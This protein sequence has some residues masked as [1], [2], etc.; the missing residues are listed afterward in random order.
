MAL[1][2]IGF[3]RKEIRESGTDGYPYSLSCGPGASEDSQE[4]K[5][6]DA[7]MIYPCIRDIEG[8]QL[9]DMDLA[10]FA[11]GDEIRIE[12][13]LRV[14][15]KEES[16]RVV[17]GKTKDSLGMGFDIISAGEPEQFS[18]SDDEETPE[19]KERLDAEEDML[20]YRPKRT[21]KQLPK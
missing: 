4:R 10:K 7:T 18:S 12:L 1:K 3:T 15:K 19:E 2:D 16:Q 6:W 9:K 14:T 11:V 5:D 20:G 17:D 8:V 21:K 13:V